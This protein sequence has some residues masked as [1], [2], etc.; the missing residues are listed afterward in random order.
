MAAEMAFSI[1]EVTPEIAAKWL[2][3]NEGNRKL[4]EPRAAAF[5]KAITDGKYRLTHQGIAFSSKGRLLDGQ[6]RLRAICLAGRPI[7]IVVARNVPESAF[8]VLDAGLTRKMYER[9][10]TDPKNTTVATRLYRMMVG[11]GSPQEYEIS[12]MMDIVGPALLKVQ[13]VTGPNKKKGGKIG[14]ATQEAAIVLRMA[15]A[16][17]DK[18]E[19]AQLNINWKL[20]KLRRGDMVGA[21]PVIAAYHQQLVKGVQTYDITVS[22]DVDDFARAWRAFDPTRETNTRLQIDDHSLVIREARDVFNTVSQGIFA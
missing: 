7:P 8:E 20:E 11:K 15:L 3:R 22:S 2:Q 12:T 17:H 10:R 13:Q 14:K 21:P 4:R 1:E 9:L 18:D 5:A 16:I 19:D 6:H